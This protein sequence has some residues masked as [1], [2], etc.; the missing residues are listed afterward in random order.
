MNLRR[1][2]SFVKVVLHPLVD[3]SFEPNQ[4]LFKLLLIRFKSLVE[5]RNFLL[6]LLQSRFVR[7]TL[8]L[9]A[10]REFV[11]LLPKLQKFGGVLV[12]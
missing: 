8:G 7:L 1:I 12:P 4:P 2:E 10:I 6:T 11:V 9:E 5:L 3:L